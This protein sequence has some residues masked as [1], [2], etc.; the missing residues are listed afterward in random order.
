MQQR[1]PVLSQIRRFG[2]IVSTVFSLSFLII[3]HAAQANGSNWGLEAWL[4]GA[5]ALHHPSD[6]EWSINLGIGAGWVPQYQG[7]DDYEGTA[8]PLI[9]IEW[10]QAYFVSTQRG[11]GIHL[12]RKGNLR[13][14]GRLTYD[15]GRSPDDN[16]ELI[17]LDEIEGSVEA[18]VFAINYAGPWRF[19]ADIRRGITEGH[20]GLLISASAAIGG[21]FSER[22][23]LIFGGGA[24][25]MDGTYG[26]AHFG[27]PSNK[28]TVF[29]PSFTVK[30]G[31]RDFDG[32]MHLVYNLTP[33]LYWSLDSRIT[34]YVGDASNSPLTK[35][36]YQA[37]TG[38]VIGM[39]F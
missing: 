9:D 6:D 34:T 31:L 11:L 24:T 35:E 27:I 2:F 12:Y 21:R 30:S 16:I 22:A 5:N 17:G 37:F 4:A 8:L 1:T 14:G 29:R 26:E 28:A 15:Q 23:S 36:T 39:R 38:M 19:F 10:R 13:L 7:S 3:S 32:F 18:G 33:R 20:E 25:W